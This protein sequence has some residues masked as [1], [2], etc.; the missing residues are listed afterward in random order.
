[1]ALGLAL[2]LRAGF[3][4]RGVPFS[5]ARLSEVDGYLQNVLSGRL[6]VNHRII[7][8]LQDSPD[9]GADTDPPLTLTLAHRILYQLQDVLHP[10]AESLGCSFT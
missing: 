9:P 4:C 3:E 6:P 8:Q 1:M 2:R 5:Q 7:Y 10:A